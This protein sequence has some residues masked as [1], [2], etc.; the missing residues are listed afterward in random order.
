MLETTLEA[1]ERAEHATMKT[2]TRYLEGHMVRDIATVTGGRY[3]R[4]RV[5]DKTLDIEVFAPERG[6]W[7]PVA[8]LSQ[9]TLDLVYLAARL[10]LVRLVTGDRRPPLVFDDPFVTLDDA[11]A[12]RALELLKQIAADFQIIYLTTSDRYDG[13]AD[14]VVELPGPT[15]VD[16]GVEDPRSPARSRT[17]RSRGLIDAAP[18][19]TATVV[20]RARRR[21]RLG[22][23]RLRRRPGEPA[24]AGLRGRAPVAVR[25]AWPSRSA[26]RV[27]RGES[28]PSAADLLLC[29]VAGVLGGDRHHRALPR[30]RDR[31]DGHRRAG[32]RR[33]RGGHPGHR[34]DRPRGRCPAPI[35][36]VGI[37]LAVVAVVLV[38]R[39][40]DE[41]GGRAGLTE[42]LIAGVAIG[43]FGVTISRLS[44]GHVFSSLTVIRLVQAVLVD[45]ASCWR[46]VR[47]GGCRRRRSR[48]RR[49]RRPR[50]GRQR[51]FLL[52]VQ[53]G[54]L[55]V[56]SVLSALYPVTTVILAAVV[57]HERVTRDHTVGIALAAAA[58]VLIGVGSA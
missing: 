57:L 18:G 33:A 32:D 9:G 15:A 28:V 58:I 6:D 40:A 12:P 13:A 47:P 38:S 54:A 52:A 51:F 11:R 7:V 5:D 36:L 20:A 16:D 49:D 30:P 55:A 21:G 37:G 10:G 2:A 46:R 27:V 4:V 24:G 35:V 41:G 26:S 34:R 29:V 53:T 39:V 19:G 3:R 50:H 43:C 31:P 1:I 48:R 14:A 25:R 23:R 8:Q 22:C 44:E 42:A 45:R 56:A 17:H